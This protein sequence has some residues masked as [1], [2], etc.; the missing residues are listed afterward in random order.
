M[1]NDSPNT[2]CVLIIGNEILSGK[3]QD[4]NLGFLGSELAQRGVR[5][6]EAR[7][8]P[9]DK[10]EIIS[11][12]NECRAKYTY[13]IT[14]GGIGPTHDDITAEC[15][16]AAFN[17]HLVLDK[18]AVTCLSRSGRELNPA[19]LKMAH[20]PEGASLI[21]NSLSNAPGF[22][23]ENVFVLA[24]VP[25]VARAMF[26]TFADD[27]GVGGSIHSRSVDVFLPEGDIAQPLEDLALKHPAIEIGSYP[28]FRDGCYGANLVVRGMDESV[29][30]KVIRLV[31]ATMRNLGDESSVGE[32]S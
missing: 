13:V 19:R 1:S 26:S 20:V 30:E 29:V 8:L 23:V 9:D 32:P 10:A 4:T 21:D 12:L 5:L 28:F 18:D 31:V 3:T 17:R 22:R 15:I 2:A 11:A 6:A 25:S 7:V 14:T 27:L 24:G 16:A